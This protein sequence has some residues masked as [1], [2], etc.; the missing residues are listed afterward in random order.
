MDDFVGCDAVAQAEL[1]RRGEVSPGELVDAAI[2]RIERWNGELNAVVTPTFELARNLAASVSD[3]GPFAGVPFLLKDFGTEWG[4]V[5]FTEGSR[6]AGDY[7]S[8]YDQELVVRYRRAGLVLCGKTNTAEF[9]LEMTTE[10]TRFGPAR[11]PW[12]LSRSPGGSS[13]GSAAA[14]A[15]GLVPMAHGNDGGGSLRQPA[16]WCGVF[17]LKPTRGR[18]PL[19]PRYGDILS[20]LFAEHVLTRS[21]RDSAVALDATCGLEPGDPLFLPPPSGAYRDDV[22]RDPSRLRIA[23]TATAFN[24]VEVD[25]SCVAAVDEAAGRCAELGH[26]ILETAPPIDVAAFEH[27]FE[28]L[29][30]AYADWV[31]IDWEERTGRTVVDGDF[32]R[33]A[34]TLAELGR[35]QSAGQ[36]LKHVQEVQRTAR[37]VGRFFDDANIDVILTPVAAVPPL[38]L[39]SSLGRRGPLT[40]GM[41]RLH[42]AR[43]RHRPAGDVGTDVTRRRR[44][45]RRRSLHRPFR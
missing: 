29:W 6:F 33:I 2:A 17:G 10:P 15:A 36:Y 21:V 31:R 42:D 19:G 37:V 22:E 27:H 23:V 20:G 30:P 32:D 24:G 8:P 14:V 26:E 38:P 34:W 11:N 45:A 12:D 39:G 28:G 44:T 7:V 35:N 3:E 25:A 13:G 16:G 5:R 9:G 41:L 4:G 18:V 40:A 1:V 43:E